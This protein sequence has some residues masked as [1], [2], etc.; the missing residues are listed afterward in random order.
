MRTD[1]MGSIPYEKSNNVETSL[2]RTQGR[3]T[4]KAFFLRFLLCVVIWSVFHVVYVYW[5][6]AE[7]QKYK[8]LGG[9]IIQKGA[10]IVE[11]RYN[12]CKT[13]DFYIVPALLAIFMLIQAI[14]RVHDVNKSG[15]CMFVPFYN[16]ILLLQRG[17]DGDNDFGL[18]PYAENKSPTYQYGETVENEMNSQYKK[19]KSKLWIALIA[20]AIVA[21]AAV[22]FIVL[23]EKKINRYEYDEQRYKKE[24]ERFEK[25]LQQ[26]SD[27][28]LLLVLKYAISRHYVPTRNPNPYF[29]VRSGVGCWHRSMMIYDKLSDRTDLL[30]Q[31]YPD[32]K[33]LDDYIA[34]NAYVWPFTDTIAAQ[35]ILVNVQKDNG[36]DVD[37]LMNVGARRSSLEYKYFGTPMLRY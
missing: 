29:D 18:L 26:A 19:Q 6:K 21:I 30:Q 37:S 32:L 15:W 16:L 10:Q 34:K 5:A 2:F 13:I 22:A 35:T 12:I 14:K 24:E 25:V 33:V 11:T 3:I 27:E 7:Y 8:E 9:G 28:E 17:T 4:R 1:D 20:M 31:I 36:L 23:E